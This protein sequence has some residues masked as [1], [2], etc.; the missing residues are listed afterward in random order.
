MGRLTE[1]FEFVNSE[2]VPTESDM[3]VRYA[4]IH[5]TPELMKLRAEYRKELKSERCEQMGLFD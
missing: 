3:R 4:Y 5:K 2:N 1:L